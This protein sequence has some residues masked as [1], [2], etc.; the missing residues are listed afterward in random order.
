[1]K[2]SCFQIHDHNYHSA[3]LNINFSDFQI[4]LNVVDICVV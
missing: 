1:M 2:Q 3:H 4:L